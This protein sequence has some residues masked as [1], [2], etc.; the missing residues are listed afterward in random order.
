M[1]YSSNE[2]K[3]W[4]AARI[5]EA[6]RSAPERLGYEGKLLAPR[7]LD[8]GAGSGTYADLLGHGGTYL[9]AIEIHAPYVERFG[10]RGKYDEV[11]FGDARTVPFPRAEV[12]I[13]GDVLEHMPLADAVAVWAKARRA[14][15]A[16]VLASL[17]IVEYPQGEVDGN[18]HEAHVHTW[19]HELVLAELAGVTDWWAGPQIGVYRARPA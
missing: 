18:A 14:A 17:P 13:L 8:I 11:I 5:W 16:A 12:V 6:L 1:P 9:T 4:M 10:L 7:V 15:T 3:D 2:G 19:S